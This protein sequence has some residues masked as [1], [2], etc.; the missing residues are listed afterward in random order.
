MSKTRR[1]LTPEDFAT[2]ERGDWVCNAEARLLYFPK[3]GEFF[4]LF[5]MHTK[6]ARRLAG[7]VNNNSYRMI[8][9]NR[10]ATGAHRWAWKLMTGEWPAGQIDHINGVRDDN[11]WSNLRLATPAQNAQN[12]G[13]RAENKSGF[14]GVSWDKT[15][16]KWVAQISING[17]SKRIG[18]FKTPEEAHAAYVAAAKALYGE[19]ARFD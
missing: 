5:R 16:E 4:R 3:T 15:A 2:P 14:K 11:R 9:H 7:Y 1:Y 13:K 10:R 8:E 17:K 18:R 6:N 12:C 19:F